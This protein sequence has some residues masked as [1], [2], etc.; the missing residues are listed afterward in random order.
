MNDEN[1]NDTVLDTETEIFTEIQADDVSE[2]DNIRYNIWL[3]SDNQADF[4]NTSVS[5]INSKLEEINTNISDINTSITGNNSISALTTAQQ[6]ELILSELKTMNN[7]LNILLAVYI[8][9]FA[10]SHIKSWK[11]KSQ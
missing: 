4:F 6:N 1:T 10:W 11:V 5:S 3:V 8:V 2:Y 7:Y 9:Q